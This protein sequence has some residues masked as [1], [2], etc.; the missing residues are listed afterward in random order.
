MTTPP[1]RHLREGARG[2]AGAC[3]D[4]ELHP[5]RAA[6]R[7]GAGVQRPDVDGEASAGHA[8]LAHLR[9]HLRCEAAG[10]LP[11]RCG[12]PAA[13]R[14]V[15][16]LG[17]RDLPFDPG[18]LPLAGG[19]PVDPLAQLLDVGRQIARRDT[20]LAGEIVNGPET[21]L[22]LGEPLGVEVESLGHAAQGGHRLGHVDRRGLDQAEDLAGAWI[23]A[24]DG[25]EVAA[26]VAERMRHRA[27][28]VPVESFQHPVAA[29]EDRFRVG[30][31][32]LL[33]RKRFEFALAGGQ[34][35][36]LAELE[37]QEIEPRGVVLVGCGEPG[38]LA[39]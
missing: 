20:V 11:P 32:A 17:A 22:H 30:E 33:G 24:R 34:P 36:E 21:A 15:L 26:D 12:E 7:R 25:F 23:V 37:A 35:F 38:Q 28:V 5:I 39:P 31:P 29:V 27:I 9:A 10:G 19:E 8:Q 1:R 13:Q 16:V 18:R 14:A 3:T 2:L 4:D 6:L